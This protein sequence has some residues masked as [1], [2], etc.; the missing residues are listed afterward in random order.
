[1]N[2]PQHTRTAKCPGCGAWSI[3][4]NI[5]VDQKERPWLI[6]LCGDCGFTESEPLP[7]SPDEWA[8]IDRR[9]GAA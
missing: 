9:G 8:A 3:R 5:A 6:E 7:G 1:M 2:T 4:P